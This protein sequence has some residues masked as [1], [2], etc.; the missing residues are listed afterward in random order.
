MIYFVEHFVNLQIK[1]TLSNPPL[2]GNNWLRTGIISGNQDFGWLTT[3]PRRSNETI[4]LTFNVNL[5]WSI[6]C[7]ETVGSHTGVT[8]CVVLKGFSN[9]QCVQVTI[10]PDLDVRRVVQFTAFTEPPKGRST[11]QV[12]LP[13]HGIVIIHKRPKLKLFLRSC[14]PLGQSV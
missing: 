3:T 4:C 12:W 8:S 6:I 11:R 13:Q 1:L 2:P 14:L 10:P 9:H 5:S 7:S